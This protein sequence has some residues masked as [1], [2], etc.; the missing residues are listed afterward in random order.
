MFSSVDHFTRDA[1]PA[2]SKSLEW[3]K[4]Y[5]EWFLGAAEMRFSQ[6]HARLRYNPLA[7]RGRSCL[8]ASA[9][10]M[11]DEPALQP[12]VAAARTEEKE[13]GRVEA[14]SDGVFA[15][16]ITLLALDLIVPH[17]SNGGSSRDLIRALARQWPSYFAF[18][19]SFF[20]VL[21]MWANHHTTF[22]LIRRV[23]AHLLFANGLLLLAATTVP[24]GTSMMAE[25]MGQP[26]AR[27]AAAVYPGIFVIG[28]LAYNW[29]WYC[30][31]HNR[32]LLK[33]GVSEHAVAKLTRSYAFGPPLYFTAVAT[34]YW[35]AYI[36]IG[37]CTALWIFWS[38]TAKD[39]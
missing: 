34:A 33:E 16:A 6:P 9:G 4:N 20:T 8:D 27:A 36:T 23:N 12:H 13:T 14:F 25:Y 3:S 17:L 2:Q 21:I 10:A 24:F 22:K 35:S 1:Y 29:V 18:V 11:G 15:V 32:A 7:A 37:I 28:S 31:A 5:G 30:A 39:S 38:L 19:T 26:G